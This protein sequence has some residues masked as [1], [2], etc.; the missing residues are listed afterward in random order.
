MRGIGA[1]K[2]FVGRALILV[3]LVSNV[4]DENEVHTVHVLQPSSK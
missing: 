4:D 3:L 2:G 1:E